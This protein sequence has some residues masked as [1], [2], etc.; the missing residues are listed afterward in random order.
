MQLRAWRFMTILVASMAMA[1]AF[2]HLLEMP[3][4][5]SWEPR[6]WIEATVTGDVFRLFETVGG[7]IEVGSCILA[8]IL[9]ALTRRHS[10]RD[11]APAAV[12]AMLFLAAHLLWWLFVLPV[13]SEFASWTPSSYPANFDAWRAQWEYA[14][15]IRALLFLTGLGA[16][17]SSSLS[18]TV[19]RRVGFPEQAPYA[20]RAAAKEGIQSA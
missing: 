3:Q 4:R 5:L 15:A 11:F 14:H 12:G 8:V 9:A 20:N 1:M 7:A 19:S 17:L 13:N 2:A 18:G 10:P 6:L 16:L